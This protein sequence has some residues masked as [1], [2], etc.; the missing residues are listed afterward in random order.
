MTDLPKM[1][2]PVCQKCGFKEAYMQ[3]HVEGHIEG[4]IVKGPS[5]DL[6]EDCLDKLFLASIDPNAHIDVVVR[7]I[8][9]RE[10]KYREK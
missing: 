8:K 7:D 10:P 9:Y 5:C 2:I 4:R 6:C 1:T 3:V